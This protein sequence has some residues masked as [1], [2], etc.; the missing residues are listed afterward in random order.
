MRRDS[1]KTIALLAAPSR[2]ASAKARIKCSQKGLALG[3]MGYRY[4]KVRNSSRSA[5]SC[6]RAVR[7][8]GGHQN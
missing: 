3:V 5:I 8:F 6:S 4:G 7:S 2:S 1:V